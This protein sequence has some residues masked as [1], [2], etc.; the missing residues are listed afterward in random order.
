[1]T[2]DPE[3]IPAGSQTVGP[4]FHIGL[5]YMIDRQSAAPL[6]AGIMIHGRVLDCDE[7]PVADAML[8]FWS[9]A[10]AE[11]SPSDPF[12]P[13]F[14]RVATDSDG[15]FTIAVP[16]PK[17]L[18]TT[19]GSS[20]APHLLALVFARGLLRHLITRV[21]FENE[22]FNASDPVLLSVPASRRATLIARQDGADSFCWDVILQGTEETVFF[23]W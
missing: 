9:A 20:Q 12:P 23:A 5:Q 18:K 17:P 14:R 11:A 16:R 15:A 7:A 3:F 6:K 22:P 1:M 19:N 4:Y 21:Y 10:C 2:I 13:G 8:E